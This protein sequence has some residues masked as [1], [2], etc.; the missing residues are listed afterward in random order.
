MIIVRVK[1]EVGYFLLMKK[2]IFR[3]CYRV[4]FK[5]EKITLIELNCSYKV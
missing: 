2:I 3:L 5:F 4:Q 1:L